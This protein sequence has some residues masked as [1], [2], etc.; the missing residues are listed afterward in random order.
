[1][2]G[3]RASRAGGLTGLV[4]MNFDGTGSYL[5]SGRIVAGH[6]CSRRREK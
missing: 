2:T 6:S 3:I 1:M 4:P 5:R